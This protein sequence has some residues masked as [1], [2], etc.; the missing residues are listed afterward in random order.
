[1]LSVASSGIVSHCSAQGGDSVVS[2]STQLPIIAVIAVSLETRAPVCVAHDMAG[3]SEWSSRVST[4]AERYEPLAAE[5]DMSL[6]DEKYKVA[7]HLSRR[8]RYLMARWT[9]RILLR[10]PQTDLV[11]GKDQLC[12][13]DTPLHCRTSSDTPT[14]LCASQRQGRDLPSMVKGGSLSAHRSSDRQSKVPKSTHG[15]STGCVNVPYKRRLGT[16]PLTSATVPLSCPLYS[17]ALCHGRAAH[18]LLLVSLP[19]LSCFPH[20]SGLCRP[21][22]HLEL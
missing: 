22:R 6:I 8:K 19:L 4:E 12:N 11:R 15:A 10:P 20:T 3:S 16:R 1:M 9:C 17:D 18:P 2:P 21:R 5:V 14:C 7:I 13:Q